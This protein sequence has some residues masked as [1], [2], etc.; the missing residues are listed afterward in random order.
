MGSDKRVQVENIGPE[1]R[2]HN[3]TF[4]I[5]RYGYKNNGFLLWRDST[6]N[7]YAAIGIWDICCNTIKFEIDK[8][9][10]LLDVMG[11]SNFIICYVWP[12]VWLVQN[13][14]GYSSNIYPPIPISSCD[15]ARISQIIDSVPSTYRRSRAG[16]YCM[17]FD[18]HHDSL[19]FL[20][21]FK[22]QCH[23]EYS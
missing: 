21:I 13:H 9:V 17:Y 22:Y 19:V 1:K 7:M 20:V 4:L 2:L 23:S 3:E 15:R 10:V 12:G 8:M 6:F 18:A 11:F 5:R 14:T 16:L